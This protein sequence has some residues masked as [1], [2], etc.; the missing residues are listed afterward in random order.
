MHRSTTLSESHEF[1][2]PR[3]T[4]S[5]YDKKRGRHHTREVIGVNK[6]QAEDTLRQ[7]LIAEIPGAVEADFEKKEE[8]Q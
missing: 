8:D 2:M 5:V 4:V 6:V 1:M 7:L 3:Y